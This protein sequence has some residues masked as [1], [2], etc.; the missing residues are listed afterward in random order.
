MVDTTLIRYQNNTI[1]QEKR[2][3][4]CRGK[5]GKGFLLEGGDLQAKAAETKN[6]EN[7]LV[8]LDEDLAWAFEE[9]FK[10]YWRAICSP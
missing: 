7:N 2:Q 1:K 5:K 6:D 4:I 9:R 8:I 10:K 3:E